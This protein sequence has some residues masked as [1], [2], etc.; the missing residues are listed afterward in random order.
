MLRAMH[1]W[2]MDNG[3]TPHI[4]V[5]A[6]ADG[7]EVPRAYV[8][9]GQIILNVSHTATGGLDLGNEWVSFEARFAGVVHHI[10]VPTGA[11]LAIYARESGEG[12]VFAESEEDGTSEGEPE[13]RE[14]G[15]GTVSGESPAGD[16]QPGVTRE[17]PQRQGG[18]K[19]PTLTV[20]K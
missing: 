15:A 4:I 19:R 5:D 11:V 14:E 10:L 12:M 16:A 6:G 7:V 17:A 3:Q 2:I 20:V 13:T 1:Q 9:Q 8:A 18:R